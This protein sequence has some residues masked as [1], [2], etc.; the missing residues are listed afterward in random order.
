MYAVLEKTKVLGVDKDG[1]T[2]RN[3]NS[4]TAFVIAFFVIA[5]SQ[6]VALINEALGNIVILVLVGISFLMLVGIFHGT[7]EIKWKDHPSMPWI[8]ALIAMG[9]VLI[10]MHAIP[11]GS[12]NVLSFVLGFL[13]FNWRSDWV[14]AL[15]F[16][17]LIII[18]MGW[19]TGG[20]QSG[21]KKED[22]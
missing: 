4:M 8:I 15:V 18:F 14:G 10:F 20:P 3:L 17:V 19:V 6:L 13:A 16:I 22:K 9:V 12:T 21:G 1:H 7:E 11:L 5:S 2:K